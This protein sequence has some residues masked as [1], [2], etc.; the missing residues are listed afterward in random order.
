[1]LL[2]SAREKFGA[3]E[4]GLGS[5][6]L[7]GVPSESALGTS[8]HVAWG[9]YVTS[10]SFVGFWGMGGASLQVCWRVQGEAGWKAQHWAGHAIMCSPNKHLLSLHPGI[11]QG[12]GS[13]GRR[14]GAMLPPFTH[15]AH[16]P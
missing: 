10:L 11:G 7:A 5:L 15:L 8:Q 6:E 4:I 16:A 9:G 12:G 3:T 13:R 1:M 2:G 14:G